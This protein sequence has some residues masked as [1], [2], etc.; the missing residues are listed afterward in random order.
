MTRKA[1]E[2]AFAEAVARLH[3]A[4]AKVAN[5]DI[6]AITALYA[7]T[8]DATS[9]YGWGGFEKGWEAVSRRWDWAGSDPRRKQRCRN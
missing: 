5:G 2:A 1:T 6:S 3:A 9:F 4:M 8:A 7:H